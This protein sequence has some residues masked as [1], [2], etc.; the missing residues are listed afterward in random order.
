MR[1]IKFIAGFGTRSKGETWDECPSMLAAQLVHEEKV[2]EYVDEPSEDAKPKAK[3]AK[4]KA[5]SETN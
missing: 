2:A 3:T 5:E 4:A 1:K